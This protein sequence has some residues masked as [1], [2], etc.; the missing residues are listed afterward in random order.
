LVLFAITE[1]Q[2]LTLA[3]DALQNVA[4]CAYLVISARRWAGVRWKRCERVRII[5]M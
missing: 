2:L 4:V 3:A 1:P 5:E